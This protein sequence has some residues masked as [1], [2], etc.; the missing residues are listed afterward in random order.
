MTPEFA[1][2]IVKQALMTAVWVSVPLLA[3]GF[4]VG[5][6]MNIVQIATSMQDSAVST[7]PRLAAFLIGFVLLMPWM[8]NRLMTYT[9]ALFGDLSRYAK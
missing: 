9:T 7:A 3:V 5:V 4:I 8:L 1:V 2:H 6:V